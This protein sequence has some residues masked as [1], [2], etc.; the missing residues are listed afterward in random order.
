MA[1]KL[2]FVR[3]VM[4]KMKKGRIVVVFTAIVCLCS[5]VLNSVFKCGGTTIRYL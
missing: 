1:E 2:V 4:F 5:L 3:R